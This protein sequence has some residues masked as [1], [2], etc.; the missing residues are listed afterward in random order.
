MTLGNKL[1][2]EKYYRTYGSKNLEEKYYGLLEHKRNEIEN[3]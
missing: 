1:E 3:P 2:T